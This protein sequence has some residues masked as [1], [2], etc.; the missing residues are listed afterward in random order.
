MKPSLCLLTVAILPA[1]ALAGTGDD[2]DRGYALAQTK[3]C[4][5]CHALS[6]HDV[7]PS[8]RAI[9]QRYRR[10]PEHRAKLPYVIRGG[11]VGHWGERFAMWPQPQLS[12]PEMKLIIDW[13]LSQ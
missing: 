12:D 5:E 1:L 9:A 7:G 13:I 11:S 6:T 3:G 2:F 10:D 4:L 8:F